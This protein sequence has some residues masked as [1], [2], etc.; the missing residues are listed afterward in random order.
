MPNFKDHTSGPRPGSAP[1]CVVD[2][3]GMLHVLVLARPR[4]FSIEFICGLGGQMVPM[5]L[6][7]L[8]PRGLVSFTPVD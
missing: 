5:L 7:I 8:L 2:L 6:P 4:L 3:S 1:P